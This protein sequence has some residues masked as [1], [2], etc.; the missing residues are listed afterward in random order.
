MMCG[1]HGQGEERLGK[2]MISGHAYSLIGAFEL[3]TDDGP[4]R[5]LKLRN[6]WGQGEWT[7]DWSDK[8]N[9]WTDEL[10]EAV[11]YT[12]RNDGIFHMTF[13]DYVSN[14]LT[15]SI[16]VSVS[17]DEYTHS[18]CLFDFGAANVQKKNF[19]FTLSE[20]VPTEDVFTIAVA[21][22]GQ[23]LRYE[24]SKTNKFTPSAIKLKLYH[25]GETRYIEGAYQRA[26]NNWMEVDKE[27]LSPGSYHIEVSIP[28]WNAC[29][30]Q[31]PDYK[32]ICIDILCKQQLSLEVVDNDDTE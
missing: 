17:P 32:K 28:Q 30:Q 13:D 10:K 18:R 23:R 6:P 26:F 9:K 2:G 7:G 1:S 8:S 5:L 15:T 20:E 14:Y 3:E 22:Q 27:N 16:C 4:L 31:N 21:Q 25:E 24:R 12:D 29:A 19:K 11:C